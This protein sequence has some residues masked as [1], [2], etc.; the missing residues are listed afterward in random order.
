MLGSIEA[1]MIATGGVGV[2]QNYH[3]EPIRAELR[4]R[5]GEDAYREAMRR[6]SSIPLDQ[7]VADLAGLIQGALG[8]RSTPTTAYPYALT[9]RELDVL[10]LLAQGKSDREIAEALF[11]GARTVETHVSNL[12]AK[13]GVHNRTEAAALATREGLVDGHR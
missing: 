1:A 5:L 7:A 8:E 12:I 13:L 2:I 3:I 6:G 4:A 10:R 11:I 9:A